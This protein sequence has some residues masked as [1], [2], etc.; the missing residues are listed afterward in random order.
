MGRRA[1]NSSF[2]E[3]HISIFMGSRG[4]LLAR[5]FLLDIVK[6]GLCCGAVCAGREVY[7]FCDVRFSFF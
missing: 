2:R 7:S 1:F 3:K 4:F 6:V 5:Y